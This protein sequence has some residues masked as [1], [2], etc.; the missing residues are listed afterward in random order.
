MSELDKY[1]LDNCP[2]KTDYCTNKSKITCGTSKYCTWEYGTCWMKDII[3]ENCKDCMVDTSI[4]VMKLIQKNP[5]AAIC[6]C[7]CV[8]IFLIILITIGGTV[9]GIKILK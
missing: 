3:K 6:A 9:L 7:A 8:V 2:A 1:C 4:D 5:V